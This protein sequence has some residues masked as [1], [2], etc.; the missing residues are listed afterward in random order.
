MRCYE[1]AMNKKTC[2]RPASVSRCMCVIVKWKETLTRSH[3]ILK[4]LEKVSVH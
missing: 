2:Q 1:G 4:Y 3:S